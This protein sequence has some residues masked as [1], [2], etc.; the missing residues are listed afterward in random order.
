MAA[1]NMPAAEARKMW[2]L[3]LLLYMMRHFFLLLGTHLMVSTAAL[4]RSIQSKKK[5]HLV[6]E[7][8]ISLT[9]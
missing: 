1:I 9:N 4:Q 2:F 5:G 7:L 8:L 3:I 6:P